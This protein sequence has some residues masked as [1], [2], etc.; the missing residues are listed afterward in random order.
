MVLH[1]DLDLKTT[2]EYSFISFH[3]RNFMG[4]VSGI[5]RGFLL[6]GDSLEA[7]Y[8][9]RG[10]E[11]QTDS[12][13]PGSAIPEGWELEKELKTKVRIR[14]KKTVGSQLEDKIWR[15]LY[16]I[17]VE[18]LSDGVFTLVL[19]TRQGV[20]K[21]KQIDVVGIDHETVFVVECKSRE[22]LGAKSLKAEI[23][24]FAGNM[25]DVRS[26]FRE[27]LDIRDLEFVF[28]MATENIIWS[29][30][31][32]HDA[33]EAGIQVW[34]EY[35]TLALQDLTNIA[36]Q[37]A[38]YQ[39]YGRIFKDKKIKGFEVKVAALQARMGGKLYYSFVLTPEDLLRIAYVHHRT[40]KSSFLEVSES[41]QRVIKTPRLRS[42]ERFIKDGGCFPGNLI[43]NF[44]KPF[45]D[46]QPLGTVD[47]RNRLKGN[48]SPVVI[49]LPPYYGSAWIIDGQHRLYGYADLEEKDTETIPVVA[50]VEQNVSFESKTFVD[51]NK[52]Q[53]AIE[54][55]LLWD[56]Y[57]DLYS[58]SA[59]D[60]ERQLYAIS[61]IAKRLA[62]DK[63]SPFF[64]QIRIPKEQNEKG[65]LTLTTIC[66]TIANQKLIAPKEALLFLDDW[67]T[68]IAYASE[69]IRIFFNVI[70]AEMPEEWAEGDS[71]YLRT[72][73]AF[74]VFCGLLR[75]LVECNLSQPE[76][77]DPRKFKGA[78]EKFLEPLLLY[79]MDL[80]P[81]KVK[82]YRGAGGALQRSRQVRYE[83]VKI[84][85]KSLPF[86]SIFVEQMEKT[87]A[88]EEAAAAMA[89]S[90]KSFLEEEE[91][92]RLEFKGSLI[93]D[94]K[95][96]YLGD[97]ELRENNAVLE[98]GVLKSLVAFLNSQG[99]EVLVGVLEMPKFA[100]VYEDKLS[101]CPVV[102]KNIV[103][104]ISLE[105]GKDGWDGYLQR[106][107]SWIET[108][109]GSDIL[110][111]GL[112]KIRNL[113][114]KGRELCH[115]SVS[116]AETKQ[117]LNNTNFY[118]RRFNSSEPLT[119]HDIDKY[120]K[121]RNSM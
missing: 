70:K 119:G 62:T 51:V 97:Q 59:K 80:A 32:R 69:K 106:L 10:S 48:A 72:N 37:G 41:Y 7:A 8:R 38:K 112:I 90:V 105:Y 84:I 1:S 113:K 5:E 29:D 85:Q 26:V 21:T 74:V 2:Y 45:K 12:L 101:D 94:L 93:S 82:E 107:K 22:Q 96:H 52:N 54:K 57:E 20:K 99:G 35:D 65:N 76:K 91:G 36:G 9:Q 55:A 103:I 53:K 87:S 114:F 56:L 18:K 109:I 81:E 14:K 11:Y 95:A 66:D 73:A 117:F 39:I 63:D 77:T 60:E 30:V 108:R 3:L 86:R 83:F 40:S 17:G 43:L 111:E 61:R 27:L 24:E 98:G 33:A 47:V 13:S 34:D 50:F 102:G 19:K 78:T 4:N 71:H 79:F 42:V 118:I 75:D 15:L 89:R 49:T 110:L 104:G 6:E 46:I 115:I 28:L 100:T 31:D 16:D 120:W 116:P 92:E 64:G 25:N 67:E 23:A 68:T 58:T 88:D 121:H 44:H